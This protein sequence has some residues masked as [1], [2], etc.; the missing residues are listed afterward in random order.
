ME[1]KETVIDKIRK[2]K[3]DIVRACNENGK[4]KTTNNGAT[5]LSRR[6]KRQRKTNKNMDL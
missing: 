2:R 1:Q 3:T 6:E 5:W 4:W